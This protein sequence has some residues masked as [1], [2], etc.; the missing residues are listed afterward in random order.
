MSAMEDAKRNLVAY[1]QTSHPELLSP[2]MNEWQAAEI[3]D[4]IEKL[5]REI[6]ASETEGKS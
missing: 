4:A 3:V 2:V 5:V 1:L 6:I